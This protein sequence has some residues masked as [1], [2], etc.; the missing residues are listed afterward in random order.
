MLQTLYLYFLC[1]HWFP[2][3]DE[4]QQIFFLLACK[5][6]LHVSDNPVFLYQLI[7]ITV[8]DKTHSSF[9]VWNIGGNADTQWRM[10]SFKH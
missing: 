7:F 8:C 6:H 5:R 2:T 9:K 10:A 3:F 4:H 1:F